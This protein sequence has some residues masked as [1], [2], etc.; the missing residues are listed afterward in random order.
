MSVGIMEFVSALFCGAHQFWGAVP[1]QAATSDSVLEVCFLGR[2]WGGFLLLS[3]QWPMASLLFLLPSFT[4][5]ACKLFVINIMIIKLLP[6]TYIC[7]SVVRSSILR[8]SLCLL[9]PEIEFMLCFGNILV[10]R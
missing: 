7:I 10:M 4:N 5:T 6:V 2:E 9:C 3:V 1:L 8:T